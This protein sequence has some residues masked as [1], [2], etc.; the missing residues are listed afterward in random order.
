MTK[1][2]IAI[3][4][5]RSG[6]MRGK[7][8][9]TV[10]GI[11]T[12]IDELKT[13][14]EDGTEISVTLKLFDHVQNIFWNSKMLETVPSFDV[15][16]FVPRGQTAL[17]D[18]MGDTIKSYFDMKEIDNTAFDSCCIYIATDGYEN[19]SRNWTKNSIK[20]LIK[21]AEE[22]YDIKVMYLAANQDAILEA[23]SMGI[24]ADRAINYADNGG[25]TIQAVYKAAASSAVRS[26][27][28]GA[29]G[30]INTEREASQRNDIPVPTGLSRMP[31]VSNGNVSYPTSNILP[32]NP[33][34]PPS[35][36][37]QSLSST[38]LSIN[39]PDITKQHR[40]LDAGKNNQWDIVEFMLDDCPELINVEG[41]NT[42]RWTLLHQAAHNNNYIMVEKF[43]SRGAD[44]TMKNRDG[45][46]AADLSTDSNIKSLL[47]DESVIVN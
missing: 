19:A 12:C 32:Q 28:G 27:S 43:L 23:Q 41:G 38:H 34:P 31:C 42:K 47:A 13:T 30:F 29:T 36:I 16:N 40:I 9:D 20:E 8:L 25:D 14:K 39:N 24:C 15:C 11:N 10:G 5:D 3:V 26:R 22:L 35:P 21:N 44:K 1:Q 37:S 17:L 18:A 6:S 45:S 46:L 7:E 2:C 33:P 4:V